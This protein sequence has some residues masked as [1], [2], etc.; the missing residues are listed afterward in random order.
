M[1]KNFTS[2]IKEMP[3]FSPLLFVSLPLKLFS[4]IQLQITFS[5]H[6]Q[7]IISYNKI[8]KRVVGS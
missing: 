5:N 6:I 3:Y 1:K 8:Y 7:L 2:L 4:Y